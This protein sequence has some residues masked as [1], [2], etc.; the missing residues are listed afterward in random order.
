MEEYRQNYGLGPP[1]TGKSTGRESGQS[2]TEY[3]RRVSLSGESRGLLNGTQGKG[4]WG[5]GVLLNL[6]SESPNQPH[7]LT[8]EAAFWAGRINAM[9]R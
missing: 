8:R 5:P 1:T 6:T 2:E 7:S 9:G 3:L 4:Y